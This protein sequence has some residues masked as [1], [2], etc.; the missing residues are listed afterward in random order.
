MPIVL[1]IIFSIFG[2]LIVGGLST[3]LL[4]LYE[5]LWYV[6]TFNFK[7]FSYDYDTV[8]EMF[9][10]ENDDEVAFSIM[11]F[12]FWPIGHAIFLVIVPIIFFFNAM[13][14]LFLLPTNIK[15][16]NEKELEAREEY[17]R[18]VERKYQNIMTKERANDFK[19]HS[20]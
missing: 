19:D 12:I 5:N 10:F 3:F 13:K 8:K 1:K 18:E 16:K 4:P 7:P 20:W 11:Y 15:E 9:V 2:Y 17:V 6:A 14:T